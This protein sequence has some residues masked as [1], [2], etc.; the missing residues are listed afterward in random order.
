MFCF[1]KDENDIDKGTEV[2]ESYTKPRIIVC[3]RARSK[4]FRD[5]NSYKFGVGSSVLLY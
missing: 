5:L 2:L 4:V 1:D 3:F